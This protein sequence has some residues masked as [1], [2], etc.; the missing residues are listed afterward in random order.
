M[1]DPTNSNS[2][3]LHLCQLIPCVGKCPPRPRLRKEKAYEFW[4]VGFLYNF[5]PLVS[6]GIN[7]LLSYIPLKIL[8]NVLLVGILDKI[9]HEVDPSPFFFS[10]YL[11]FLRFS[12]LTSKQLFCNF[13]IV[14]V[15][16]WIQDK[17]H[18]LNSCVF[19]IP[20]FWI[21]VFQM[22]L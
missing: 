16:A 17:W 10:L 13:P 12:Y 21:H 20:I 8:W 1:V 7:W 4:R 19:P 9:K 3:N 11:Q 6:F 5:F 22:R 2:L 15:H 14:L 18:R